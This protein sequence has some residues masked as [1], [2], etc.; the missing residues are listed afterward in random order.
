MTVNGV[1]DDTVTS[2]STISQII[3]Y[4]GKG[5]GT[6]SQ[7]DPSVT[8]PATISGG[9]GIRNRLVW[10]RRRDPRARLVRLHDLGRRDRPESA[11][12]PGGPRPVQA[13][14]VDHLG[15][16]RR[17]QETDQRSQPDAPRR[18]VSTST[19]KAT[20]YQSIKFLI[21][22]HPRRSAADAEPLAP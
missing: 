16:R 4:G 2:T 17:T 6:R 1:V 19:S 20:W 15:L 13:E 10:R 21:D 11:H 7:I 22:W 8:V 14:Q 5:A 12:R 18:N 9:Q 3:V